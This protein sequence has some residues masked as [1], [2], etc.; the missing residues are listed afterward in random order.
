M[1]IKQ[2][3]EGSESLK[4]KMSERKHYTWKDLKRE[5]VRARQSESETIRQCESETMR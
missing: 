3:C 2:N 4:S 1:R 5:V